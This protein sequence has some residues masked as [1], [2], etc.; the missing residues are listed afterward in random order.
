MGFKEMHK[1]HLRE[2][3]E[4]KQREAFKLQQKAQKYS[5]KLNKIKYT[6]EELDWCRANAPAAFDNCSDDETVE[7]MHA[8]YVR[9]CKE[10]KK[11]A[12]PADAN[13]I[14]KIPV[15]L[16]AHV[17]I[18][19]TDSR[20]I[21]KS[22]KV[23]TDTCI[24]EVNIEDLRG[25]W[26][27]NFIGCDP[28]I[29][30]FT[31]KKPKY[32]MIKVK[33][34]I[35][36]S[37]RI[38][39]IEVCE[40]RT[41]FGE[42]VYP[43]FKLNKYLLEKMM[44]LLNDWV[45]CNNV[46]AEM[47][48]LKALDSIYKIMP[49]ELDSE[50][51]SLLTIRKQHK[52][53]LQIKFADYKALLVSISS[54]RPDTLSWVNATDEEIAA[55]WMYVLANRDRLEKGLPRLKKAWEKTSKQNRKIEKINGKNKLILNTPASIGDDNISMT[56]YK[57]SIVKDSDSPSPHVSAFCKKIAQLSIKVDAATTKKFI[58]QLSI[59]QKENSKSTATAV[60]A[61]TAQ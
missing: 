4:A 32:E 24:S 17:A 1:Q 46:T 54:T 45:N 5:D 3:M 56:A 21:G 31:G 41:R 28:I 16:F 53:N 61:I 9:F 14:D 8:A 51:Q 40:F 39:G 37:I 22:I 34:D 29:E 50:V 10:Q 49:D 15:V 48:A 25:W 47:Y 27:G 35:G 12:I 59:E 57:V 33:S 26:I 23:D 11:Q 52:K 7:C 60:P 2:E 18:S 43:L 58:K 30:H 42:E 38:D 20:V 36:L 19:M 13:D 55:D 6:Q 44:K